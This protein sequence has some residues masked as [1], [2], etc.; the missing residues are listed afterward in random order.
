M[1]PHDWADDTAADTPAIDIKLLEPV[2]RELVAASS[3]RATLVIVE[4]YGGTRLGVP[5]DLEADHPL[6]RLVG[7]MEARQI[8][9]HFGGDRPL[10]PKAL[11]ALT[12]IRDAQIKANPEGLSVPELARRHGLGE[13]RIYQ[14]RGEAEPEA[15]ANP[16]RSLFD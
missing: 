6:A 13:R 10:I 12:A 3:L 7:L 1:T 15:E 16:T 5:K 4:V 11:R 2:L 14:I 8:A 9:R